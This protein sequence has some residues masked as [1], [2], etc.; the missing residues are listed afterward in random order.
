MWGERDGSVAT[1]R[2]GFYS[3]D[4]ESVALSDLAGKTRVM[5]DAFIAPSGTD[6]NDAFR[7]H[8]RPLPGS[9][10]PDAYRLRP[11]RAGAC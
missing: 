9:A 4:C 1:R 8:P 5:D 7:L 3:A 10:M 11:A 2:T 6:V